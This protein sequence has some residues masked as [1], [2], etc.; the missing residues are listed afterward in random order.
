MIFVDIRF[1]RD[2]VAGLLEQVDCRR[3]VQAELRP[4]PRPRAAHCARR[5]QYRYRPTCC[6]A[7]ASCRAS[8]TGWSQRNLRGNMK[9]SRSS[10]EPRNT[11]L[12]SGN[13]GSSSSNPICWMQSRRRTDHHGIAEIVEIAEIDAD[14]IAR[15]ICS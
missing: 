5:M 11:R 3:G 12:S 6:A 10:S 7:W 4:A 13:S 15:S 14:A 8:P 1:D 9:Y 2:P